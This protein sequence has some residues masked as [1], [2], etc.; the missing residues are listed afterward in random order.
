VRTIQDAEDFVQ[1]AL[2]RAIECGIPDAVARGLIES[3]EAWLWTVAERKRKADIR[4][5]RRRA[6]LLARA[7]GMIQRPAPRDPRLEA[8]LNEQAEE[9]RATAGR[10]PYHLG[11]VVEA[12]MD[13]RSLAAIARKLGIPPSTVQSRSARARDILRRELRRFR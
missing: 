13:G 3:A 11:L 8:V 6:E 12:L 10:L 7:A 5:S 2:L 1:E 4:K 9:V